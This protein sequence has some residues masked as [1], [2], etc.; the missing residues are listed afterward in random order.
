M[1]HRNS[2]VVASPISFKDAASVR[3]VLG[4]VSHEFF[5]CWNVE[6]IRP[7]TLE[8]FNFE[9]ANISGELWL[10]EGFTQY[11]GAADHGARRPRRSADQA[12]RL[13]GNALAVI[14]GPGRQFHSAVEM[15]QM[16]PFTDAAAAIDRNQFLATRSSPTT[17][18]AR[19]SRGARL[20]PARPLRRQDHARRLHARDVAGARQAGRAEPGDR[21]EAVHAEGCARSAR[22]G[23]G[24]SRVRRRLLRQVH[25]RARAC[26]TTRA[27][28]ARAGLVLRKPQPAGGLDWRSGRKRAC[29]VPAWTSV[30]VGRS[31]RVTNRWRRRHPRARAWGSP[32]FAAG[33]EEADVITTVDG[34]PVAASKNGG[35]RL[36]RADPATGLRSATFATGR[37]QPR[38]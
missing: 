31:H 18:T 37:K 24:R 23:V 29:R 10:A 38:H 8:P 20:E 5:H 7:K 22:G 14:N 33:L 36:A 35:R 4:T 9:E 12:V 27:L 17:P 3:A 11:Y 13:A 28:F 21:G 19:R 32:A 25:R 30:G 16:A 15:S 26:R 34:R 2:T 1:E 6:R